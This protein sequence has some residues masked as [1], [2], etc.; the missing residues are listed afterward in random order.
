MNDPTAYC[1]KNPKV[2]KMLLPG[3]RKKGSGLVNGGFAQK[4]ETERRRRGM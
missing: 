4:V 3:I 2:V 1:Y